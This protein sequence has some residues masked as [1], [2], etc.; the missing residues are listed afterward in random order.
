MPPL[1]SLST[2]SS[3]PLIDMSGLFNNRIWGGCRKLVTCCRCQSL[4]NM[5]IR[6]TFQVLVE[7]LFELI[8]WN[9]SDL[10][11]G[12]WQTVNKSG[13]FTWNLCSL[14]LLIEALPFRL[15]ICASLPLLSFVLHFSPQLGTNPSRIFQV[16][17]ILYLSILH[18]C[19][20]ICKK[21]NLWQ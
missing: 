16:Y 17:I 11:K 1:D 4:H 8:N 10:P 6:N 12:Y 20:Y 19:E 15:G 14:S 18:C 13:P 5:L 21:I 3:L 9:F 7:V 2:R